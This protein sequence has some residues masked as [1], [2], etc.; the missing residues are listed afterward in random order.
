MLANFS[1]SVTDTG[2]R[3]VDVQPERQMVEL[4]L[5]CVTA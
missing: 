5:A 1:G 3:I 2:G 4:M